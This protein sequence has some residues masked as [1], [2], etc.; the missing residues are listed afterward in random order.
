MQEAL[1]GEWQALPEDDYLSNC[2][3]EAD[4]RGSGFLCAFR[5]CVCVFACVCACYVCQEGREGSG[6]SGVCFK[7][8]GCIRVCLLVR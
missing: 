1:E 3:A 8:S 6:G 4:P 7:L 2:P 5:S